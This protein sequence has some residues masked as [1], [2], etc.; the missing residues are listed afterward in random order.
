[1]VVMARQRT[2]IDQGRQQ[3]GGREPL[4][5]AEFPTATPATFWTS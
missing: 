2:A 4:G 1:M 3:L 5:T